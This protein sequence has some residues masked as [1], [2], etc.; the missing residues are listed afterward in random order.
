VIGFGSPNKADS[1]DAHGAPL[2]AEE[3]Q[4]T[5][6]QL[7]WKYGEFEVPDQVYAAFKAHADEGAKKEEEWKKMWA[8]YQKAEPELAAQFQRCCLDKKLPENW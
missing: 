3:A 1:H 6:D 4:A 8:E 5:R 2:G 7:G